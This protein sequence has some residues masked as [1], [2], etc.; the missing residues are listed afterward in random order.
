MTEMAPVYLFSIPSKQTNGRVDGREPKKR[1]FPDDSQSVDAVARYV[2][3]VCPASFCGPCDYALYILAKTFGDNY[4][5]SKLT[6]TKV[7]IV[8]PLKT[9]RRA[10]RRNRRKMSSFIVVGRCGCAIC[11]PVCFASFCGPR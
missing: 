4:N 10:A 3:F 7:V 9:D 6:T 5:I 8:D 1:V 11:V 2:A